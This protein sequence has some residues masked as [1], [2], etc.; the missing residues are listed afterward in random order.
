[1]ADRTAT[2]ISSNMYM[3]QELRRR[4]VTLGTHWDADIFA[5][6]GPIFSPF[7]SE[8]RKVI[9]TISPRKARL[10]VVLETEGGSIETTE[11][12]GN[13]FRHFYKEV[14][15]VVPSYA[16]SAGTVLAMSGDRIWMD[17]YSV[18]GPGAG[19]SCQIR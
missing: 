9:A 12:I 13:L 7:D 10:C 15:F 6:I 5:Y 1:M 18:L 17:Y 14:W 19:L 8:I 2:A 11:R 16:M 4:G 3:E